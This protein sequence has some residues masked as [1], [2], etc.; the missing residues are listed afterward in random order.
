MANVK[1]DDSTN[2]ESLVKKFITEINSECAA[3]RDKRIETAKKEAEKAQKDDK[4]SKKKDD[5]KSAEPPLIT[6]KMDPSADT[7]SRSPAD[8]AAQVVAGR[9]SVCWSAHMADKARHVFMYVDGKGTL[10]PK[11]ALGDDFDDFKKTWASVMSSCG[12]RNADGKSGWCDWDAMHLE[13]PDGKITRSDERA[14]AC[15]EEYA[16]LSRKEGKGTNDKFEK[17]YA[18]ELKEYLEKYEAKDKK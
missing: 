18:K 5:K 12:L 15:L 11:K 9:S 16:R 2:I 7:K 10:D 17:D 13:V 6:F 1:D 8:Q 4:D 3:M 14:K